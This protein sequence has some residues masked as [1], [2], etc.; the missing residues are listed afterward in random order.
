MDE[1]SYQL[2][3]LKLS[4]KVIDGDVTVVTVVFFDLHAVPPDILLAG[5]E[6]RDRTTPCERDDTSC[7]EVPDFDHAIGRLGEREIS[8]VGF[9]KTADIAVDF[10]EHRRVSRG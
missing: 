4:C 5:L 2:G 1:S 7:L 6:T 3:I 8:G 10:C 9:D